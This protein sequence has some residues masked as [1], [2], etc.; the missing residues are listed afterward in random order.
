MF[1]IKLTPNLT[2]IPARALLYIV[3]SMLKI[4]EGQVRIL[5][6]LVEYLQLV[7]LPQL[8][9]FGVSIA[10]LTSGPGDSFN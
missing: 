6:Q 8:V 9:N 3:L 10:S 2:F 5:S 1:W 7:G 4:N